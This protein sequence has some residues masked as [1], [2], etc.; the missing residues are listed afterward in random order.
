MHIPKR[1]VIKSTIVV[2][3]DNEMFYVNAG[4]SNLANNVLRRLQKCLGI[5]WV[6]AQALEEGLVR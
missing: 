1:L 2:L 3:S 5:S 4:Y 6:I